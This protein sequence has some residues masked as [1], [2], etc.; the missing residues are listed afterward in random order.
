MKQPDMCT[1]CVLPKTDQ[2]SLDAAGLCPLCRSA[3]RL[4]H[5]ATRPDPEAL[6][7]MITAVRR[8]GS[9]ANFDCVVAWSG[10]RDSTFMLRELVR[11]HGLRCLAVFGRT[12]FTP[13]EIVDNVHR[14]AEQ[15]NVTLYEIASPAC[16]IDIARF[17][18]AEWLR[19]PQPILINLACA[20][21]K[22]I[23]RELFRTAARFGVRT[24]I[25]GGNPLEYFHSGPASIDI[26]AKDRY[27]FG[28]MI[29]DAVMRLGRG[30]RTMMSAPALYRHVLLLARASLL[31]VNQYTLFMRLRYARIHRFDYYYYAAWEERRVEAALRELAWRLPEGC[32]TSWRADC[33]FEAVKNAAFRRQL[34]YTYTH[35]LY[36]NMIRAGQLTREE[37]LARLAH[38]AA[39]EPRLEA[40][41]SILNLPK[42]CFSAR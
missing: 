33:L 28:P 11:R 23:N 31:Y 22:F 40:A 25:Y 37:A 15:L 14:I 2:L 36:S 21:C 26:N 6:E 38:E 10:G 12:P 13:P 16:H 5:V 29:R 18:L 35:A 20:P 41:L 19:N 32:V 4:K 39:S 7:A 17:C 30:V 3:A 24:V 34:G 27:S 8:R 1:V 9:G 42:Q